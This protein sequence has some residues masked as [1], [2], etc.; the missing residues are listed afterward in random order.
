MDDSSHPRTSISSATAPAPAAARRRSLSVVSSASH[1]SRTAETAESYDLAEFSVADGFRPTDDSSQSDLQS[2]NQAPSSRRLSLVNSNNSSHP[3]NPDLNIRPRPSS[4]SKPHR[5]HESLTLRNDGSGAGA[6]NQP[7]LSAASIAATG[8]ANNGPSHNYGDYVQGTAGDGPASAPNQSG[9]SGPSRPTHPYAL[10]PQ[11]TE[12]MADTASES[13]PVGF[14]GLGGPYQRPDG[15]SGDLVGPLGHM[16]E[17]PPYTRYPEQAYTRDPPAQ[18]PT[19]PTTAAAAVAP[20]RSTASPRASTGT[21]TSPTAAAAS[22]SMDAGPTSPRN[23]SP[24][25]QEPAVDEEQQ[26]NALAPTRSARSGVASGSTRSGSS[27]GPKDYGDEARPSMP[28]W[29][30]RAKTKVLGIIPCWAICLLI[31]ALFVVGIIMGAVLGVLLAD[32]PGKKQKHP[33]PQQKVRLSPGSDVSFY[34]D[35]E[36]PKDLKSLET[37][38]FDLD[39]LELSATRA[40]CLKDG[41]QAGA[42]SCDVPQRYYML[43]LAKDATSPPAS[44]Y[45]MRLKLVNQTQNDWYWGTQPPDVPHPA[46]LALVNDTYQP[47]HGPAWWFQMPYSKKV[48]L[49]SSGLKADSSSSSSKS[50]RHGG[51]Y[52][53][54]HDGDDHGFDGFDPSKMHMTSLSTSTPGPGDGDIVWLCTWPNVTM[55][56]FIYTDEDTST[57]TTATPSA[58]TSSTA[59]PTTTSSTDTTV[60]P[61]DMPNPYPRVVKMVERRLTGSD[62]DVAAQCQQ[63][64]VIKGGADSEAVKDDDGNYVTATIHEKEST[65]EELL[66]QQERTRRPE[67]RGESSSS[68]SGEMTDCSCLWWSD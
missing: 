25:N 36:V 54:H 14:A 42:W 23:Q 62:D 63:I 7:Q 19:A 34:D 32:H 28:K 4:I 47:S 64:R 58:T 26:Q 57:S 37:G 3:G 17:L 52:D 53:P 5:P 67:R 22:T 21:R 68:S 65:Y 44:D 13:I 48:L 38:N 29:K 33:D 1:G 49:P 24:T 50:K 9:Y 10:Y 16:E 61:P 43:D 2:R 59:L 45:T 40:D 6:A 11:S 31:F 66:K 55:E 51:W 46:T 20:A 27:D 12:P 60:N 41:S 30:R 18:D 56:V 35:D 15:E 39:G 8:N